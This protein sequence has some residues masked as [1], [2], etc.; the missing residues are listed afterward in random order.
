[1]TLKGKG[2]NLQVLAECVCYLI[3]GC[4]L[5]HLTYSGGYL[6]YVTPRMKPYLYGLSLL[7]FLWAVAE[8][9][10]LLAPQYKARL[11]RLFV[12]IIP[13]LVLSIRPPAPGGSSMARNYNSS[14]IS[15]SS[16]NRGGQI[17]GGTG[18]QTPS[19]DS[20]GPQ[21][22]PGNGENDPSQSDWEGAETDAYQETDEYSKDDALQTYGEEGPNVL[23]GLDEKGKTITIA[24]EDYY[25][26][27]QELSS[28][29][30]KYEGYTIAMKGFI[31][32]D[33]EIEKECDF[34][35]VRLSMWCCAAD[36]TPMGFLVDYDGKLEY[37]DDDWVVVKGTIDLTPDGSSIIMK[38]QSIEPAEKPQ[39]EY[40]Y[41]YF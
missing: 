37:K 41:P 16:G 38:A 29:T 7:M 15:M 22:P 36:L 28:S 30:E 4:L 10:N 8:G 18:Q 26:W 17:T 12:L 9:R 5:F 11:S 27:L 34:A 20:T 39:E 23:N 35:L 31:Y 40:V 1:M 6:S 25:G 32:R 13:I 14:G 24:D 21:E 33:P 19:P 2:L 3:F